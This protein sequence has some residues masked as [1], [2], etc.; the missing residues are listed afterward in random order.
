MREDLRTA[1]EAAGTLV[2]TGSNQ[3]KLVMLRTS[4]EQA[5]MTIGLGGTSLRLFRLLRMI[6]LYTLS[7]SEDRQAQGRTHRNAHE[8]ARSP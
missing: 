6:R 2:A 5:V 3:D 7:P 4:K 8:L 1:R